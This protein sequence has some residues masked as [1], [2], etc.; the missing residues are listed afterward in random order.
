MRI[1][2]PNKE[3]DDTL[4]G[5]GEVR[6][7]TAADNDIAI[8]GNGV[9]PCHLRLRL[10]ERGIELAV[11]DAQAR[12]HVNTRPV[13]EKAILRLGDVVSVGSV[14]FVLK[15]DRDTDIRTA[16]PQAL[17]PPPLDPGRG[18]PARVLL[19]GL[20][21]T[22]FGKI[23]PIRGRLV[24]GH[25]DQADLELDEPGILE[26]HAVIEAIGE[27]IIL[28]GL[29]TDNPIQV[30]GVPVSAAVVQAADQ[31]CF[32]HERFLVEAPG[33][34]QRSVLG[35]V[36]ASRPVKPGTPRTLPPAPL[37]DA[38]AAAAA[39]GSAPV[40][41]KAEAETAAAAAA[42][43]NDIWWLIAVAAII[44]VGLAWLFLGIG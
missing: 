15:P 26:R 20:S 39:A 24:V 41:V 34:P 5:A 28:R 17:T 42:D 8:I 27:V 10:S 12:T 14:P 16:I 11:A 32:G 21:G 36:P 1:F 13:R 43:R 22:H 30:N 7:G 19:R 6:I 44:A 29:G 37:P 40:K 33:L 9:A 38:R 3:R 35:V 4:V 25:G 31:I 18:L 23:V 2:F